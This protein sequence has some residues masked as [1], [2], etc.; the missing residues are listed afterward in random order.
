MTPYNSGNSM[1]DIR[2]LCRPFFVTA[3]LR[4]I[5]HL[6]YSSEAVTRLDYQ[7]LLK[8]PPHNITGWMRSCF[9]ELHVFQEEA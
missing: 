5:L 3:V 2:P 4:S 9:V 6:S 7:I 1:H 8:L